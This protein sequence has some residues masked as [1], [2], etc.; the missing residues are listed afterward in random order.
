MATPANQPNPP[1]GWPPPG[2]GQSTGIN[3][4]SIASTAGAAAGTALL[5]GIGTAAGAALGNIIGGL[6]GNAQSK[7]FAQAGDDVHQ[8]FRGEVPQVFLDWMKAR[9]PKGFT[10]VDACK[11]LYWIWKLEYEGGRIYGLDNPKFLLQPWERMVQLF[12]EMGIDLDA[13]MEK[14]ATNPAHLDR[15]HVSPEDVVRTVPGAAVID[16]MRR[17]QNKQESGAP[18]DPGERRVAN[19]TNKLGETGF[20]LSAVVPI[21]VA[22]VVLV[23]LLR[24]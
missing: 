8:W 5:P 10:S 11:S 2:G 22:A 14:S 19:A 6:F 7:T 13:S 9:Y 23:L 18:L 17:V 20:S 21:L 24:R 1:G 16:E 12:R 15:Y 3:V 4:G